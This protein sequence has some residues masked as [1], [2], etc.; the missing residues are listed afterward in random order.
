MATD[1]PISYNEVSVDRN[2][3]ITATETQTL[4]WGRAG[5]T[6][7]EAKE[8]KTQKTKAHKNSGTVGPCPD[9]TGFCIKALTVFALGVCSSPIFGF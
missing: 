3:A 5:R 6:P 2:T 8:N 4:K 9:L 7:C 1:G